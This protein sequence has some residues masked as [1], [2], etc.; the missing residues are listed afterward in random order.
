MKRKQE[1]Y[2]TFAQDC[3][4]SG[5]ETG[6]DEAAAMKR[7]LRLRKGQSVLDAPCGAG[8]ISFH[9]AKAGCRATGVDRMGRFIERARRRFRKEGLKGRFLRRDLRALDFEGEFDAVINF[10]GSFGYFS[11]EE[12]LLVLRRFGL[13]LKRGGRVLVDQLN[14]EHVLRHFRPKMEERG[15]TLRSRWNRRAQRIETTWTR[16]A[17]GKRQSHPSSIRLYTPGQFPRLFTRAGLEVEAVYGDL[18][19]GQYTR[20]SRRIYVVGRKM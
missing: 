20:G 14:R 4:L 3:W 1:W 12:N 10:G 5:D 9:L 6:A 17:R 19:G 8:R 18:A 2:E 16:T 13:A 11:E 7:L 15:L